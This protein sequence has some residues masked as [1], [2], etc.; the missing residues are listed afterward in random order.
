MHGCGQANQE[1]NMSKRAMMEFIFPLVRVSCAALQW[2]V[3]EGVRRSK[4]E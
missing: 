2:V 3:D 1:E 4:L